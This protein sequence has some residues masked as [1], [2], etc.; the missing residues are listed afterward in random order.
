MG[1]ELSSLS[2]FSKPLCFLS[3]TYTLTLKACGRQEWM[4]LTVTNT[5]AYRGVPNKKRFLVAHASAKYAR[6]FAPSN[7]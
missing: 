2:Q 4:W 3:E 7:C 1:Q 6:V 5:L